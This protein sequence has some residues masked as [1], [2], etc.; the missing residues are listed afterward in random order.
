MSV[1]VCIAFKAAIL[2]IFTLSKHQIAMFNVEDAT[3]NKGPTEN[4]HLSLHF[5]P[6][7]RTV[8]PSFSSV[9]WFYS[10]HFLLL[11]KGCCFWLKVEPDFS[12]K[13]LKWHTDLG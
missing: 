6:A 7:I 5:P 8:L 11:K 1:G 9:F 3:H 2:N 12:E 10:H 4:L 13:Y